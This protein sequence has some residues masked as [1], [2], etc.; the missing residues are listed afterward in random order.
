MKTTVLYA[1]GDLRIE[2]KPEPKAGK[3]ELVLEAKVGLT[4]GTDLKRYKRGYATMKPPYPI[5]HE[6]SGV[7]AEV[8]EGVEG[9]K[10]GDRVVSH[11]TAPCGVCYYCKVGDYS[12]CDNLS[13]YETGW[14]Q[15]V[16][17]PAQIVNYNFVFHL[18]DDMS[19]K[20]AA[21]LEPLTSAEN[22]VYQSN[23][24]QGDYV[25]ILGCGPL[26]LF[27]GKLAR[28]RGAIVIAMDLSEFRLGIAQKLGSA[29]ITINVSEVDDQVTALRNA[30]PDKRGVD[31]A[32]EAVG[33]PETWEKA[34]AM[35][36]K[37]GT[38]T[39]FGG[40]GPDT[41]I[42]VD[43]KLLHYGQV[44]IKGVFHTIPR[45]V[46]ASFTHLQYGIFDG[47]DFVY[48]EYPIEEA[49]KALI[50]HATGKVIKNAIIF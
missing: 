17:I 25:A 12:M 8:G 50:E 41:T 21:L 48:N 32:L 39:L 24:K 3:G 34:I 18:P 29:D 36:R 14:Q 40:C 11:I 10:V 7:V 1:P 42:T 6:F 15:Y 49:E 9:Y 26:G 33:T 46:N 13:F 43:T 44:T 2:E 31:V 47:K 20:T 30:T 22:G 27:M 28:L 45:L 38:A 4:C 5:G 19:F 16:K 35:V 23:I 37:G